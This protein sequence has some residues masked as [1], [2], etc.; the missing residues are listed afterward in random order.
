[1]DL[2]G[3]GFES[4]V[5]NSA[6][7]AALLEGAQCTTKESVEELLEDEVKGR[8]WRQEVVGFEQ[9]ML[10]ENEVRVNWQTGSFEEDELVCSSCGDRNA[11]DG[12]HACCQEECKRHLNALQSFPFAAW[13]DISAAPLDP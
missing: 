8:S 11:W 13:G 6:H 10:E 7:I 4:V 3:P 12:V 2:Q 5:T 9:H 1:M